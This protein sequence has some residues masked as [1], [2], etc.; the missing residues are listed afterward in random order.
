MG[1]KVCILGV[2]YKAGVS[3]IRESP[4]L[5]IIEKL[6]AD[7]ADVSYHDPYVPQLRELDLGSVDLDD[8]LATAD[9]VC[10][11]TAHKDLDY[12]RVVSSARLVVDFRGVTRG[13]EAGNVVLVG[14]SRGEPAG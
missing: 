2:A 9:A 4:A 5:K 8:A 3:D 10:I 7:G 6:Q 12:E 14:K 11:V 1:S 13:L